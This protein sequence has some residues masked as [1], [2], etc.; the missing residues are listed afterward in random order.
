MPA[1]EPM[2]ARAPLAALM[3]ILLLSGGA[4][5]AAAEQDVAGITIDA[6]LSAAEI[7]QVIAEVRRIDTAPI[8]F[9]VDAGK[10][11]RMGAFAEGTHLAVMMGLPEPG[12][13]AATTSAPESPEAPGALGVPE[14]ADTGEPN[15][16]LLQR[17]GERWI[18]IKTAK[19]GC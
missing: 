9:I 18:V 7:Q 14:A 1:A 5:A 2:I 10:G 11:G 17:Q 19:L 6:T 4:R 12:D 15:V 13:A 16:H 8:L 3:A